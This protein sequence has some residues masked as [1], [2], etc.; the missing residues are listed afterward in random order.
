MAISKIILNGVTQMDVTQ[1]TV[2]SNNLLDDY[3]ATGADGNQVIGSVINNGAIGGTIATQGG[4]YTIPAGYTSGG[5]VTAFIPASTITNSVLNLQ[6]IEEI[7][8]DYGVQ[9][10]ITI[11]AGYYDQTTLTKTL[12][13][14]LPAPSTAAAAPQMLAAYQA[15][16]NEG[17]LLTG[18]MANR[19]DWGATLNDST[20]SVTIPAGYHDGTGIVN[21]T[22]VNIPDPTISVSASG[23]ITASGT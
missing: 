14:I 20:T 13:T 21:H 11:P 4:T 10:S 23:L 12:S 2:A 7:S 8:G 6:S 16:N 22:T 19:E 1:N 9:A 3:I 5:T 17:Q 15:Y 18:T